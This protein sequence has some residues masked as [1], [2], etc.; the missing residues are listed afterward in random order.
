MLP[1]G[2]PQGPYRWLVGMYDPDTRERLPV[3]GPEGDLPER[4]ISLGSVQN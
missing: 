2:G 1:Q 3:I 4:A